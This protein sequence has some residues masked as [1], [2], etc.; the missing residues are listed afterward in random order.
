MTVKYS[1]FTPATLWL[2]DEAGTI[3]PTWIGRTEALSSQALYW[4][5]PQTALRPQ[6]LGL[7]VHSCPPT[8]NMTA[9]VRSYRGLYEDILAEVCCPSHTYAAGERATE[10]N[11]YGAQMR[12]NDWS[13]QRVLVRWNTRAIR[14]NYVTDSTGAVLYAAAGS[15]NEGVS[16]S[17]FT[18][19]YFYW[20]P[21]ATYIEACAAEQRQEP[22]LYENGPRC[23]HRQ[24]DR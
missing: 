2:T 22:G 9:A 12:T 13:R 4:D 3:S 17:G 19:G 10:E 23:R 11:T 14:L 16:T 21:M 6:P 7:Q 1:G 18:A 15:E 20:T 24:R 8:Y 5:S